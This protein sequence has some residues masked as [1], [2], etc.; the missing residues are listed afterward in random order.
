MVMFLDEYWEK[1]EK[2]RDLELKH[3]IENIKK[4]SFPNKFRKGLY[5]FKKIC[6]TY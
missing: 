3:F 4:R 6:Y 2:L 1:L 5:F